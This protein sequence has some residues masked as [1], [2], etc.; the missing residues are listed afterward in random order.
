VAPRGALPYD[1][2]RGRTVALR[3]GAGRLQ[4]VRHFYVLSWR[5]P[6][7]DFALVGDTSV[8]LLTLLANGTALTAGAGPIPPGSS[9]P[10]WLLAVALCLFGLSGATLITRRC[11]RR[12]RDGRRQLR[13]SPGS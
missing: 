2:R 7:A 10:R 6:Q 9:A 1:V 13:T 3:M 4:S 11:R 5:G 8:P 12:A